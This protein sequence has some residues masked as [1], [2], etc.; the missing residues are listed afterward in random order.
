MS[1]NVL[2]IISTNYDHIE[3]QDSILD[4]FFPTLTR[5]ILAALQRHPPCKMLSPAKARLSLLI[6][7]A[8]S[9][10]GAA[11]ALHAL[12]AGHRVVGTT[13]S[14][15]VPTG[16]VVADI[17]A[18]GG[19][20]LTS[21]DVTSSSTSEVVARATAEHDVDVLVNNAGYALLGALEDLSDAEVQAQFDANFHG[22][23]R[24]V[25]GVL[26]AFRAQRRGTIVNVSSGAGF[27]G[28]PSRGAYAAS[29]F[30]LEGA[31]EAL[32]LEVRDFG[33]R[34]LLIELGAFRTPF[35]DKIHVPAAAAERGG[36][37][38]AYDGSAVEEVF[39]L[40]RA[41]NTPEGR[42]MVRGDPEQAA[43]ILVELCAREG[44][45][46]DF[47]GLRVPLG[48]DCVKAY[49]MKLESFAADLKATR[50]VAVQSDY[51][52]SM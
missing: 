48:T 52:A 14:P 16:A 47:D 24:C 51:P 13:R 35:A 36:M 9:G 4:S 49:E 22:A 18:A 12:R 46:K 10:L 2:C 7:G 43:K 44:P 8:S 5:N 31:S 45:L 32:A 1:D 23:L 6:T 33:V 50:A 19:T 38:E 27:M 29:K 28:R 30:A 15:S 26:P 17:T 37:S 34:V 41:M 25:R 40:S 39:R 42:A 21:F 20:W 11:I 3:C